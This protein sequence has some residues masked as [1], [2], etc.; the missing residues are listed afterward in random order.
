MCTVEELSPSLYGL[1]SESCSYMAHQPHGTFSPFK[2]VTFAFIRN[3]ITLPNLISFVMMITFTSYVVLSLGRRITKYNTRTRV[4]QRRRFGSGCWSRRRIYWR[5]RQISRSVYI[6][7]A[8]Q[9]SIKQRICSEPESQERK[10]EMLTKSYPDMVKRNDYYVSR[11]QLEAELKD[12]NEVMLYKK[13]NRCS[14]DKGKKPLR[15]RGCTSKTMVSFILNSRCKRV[16]KQSGFRRRTGRPSKS[17]TVD[18]Q[19]DS[20]RVCMAKSLSRRKK[21]KRKKCNVM[22]Q[23]AS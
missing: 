7:E 16:K 12:M 21:K 14:S 18:G 19:G 2:L 17:S 1:E 23:S 9:G 3:L 15:K 11:G 10:E 8:L 5:Q 13:K 6:V 4:S 22:A 20:K